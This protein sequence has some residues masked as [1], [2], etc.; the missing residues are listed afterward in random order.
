MIILCSL[1]NNNEMGV[2]GRSDESD[3][4]ARSDFSDFFGQGRVVSGQGSGAMRV[5]SESRSSESWGRVAQPRNWLSEI[6][7]EVSRLR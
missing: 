2:M 5:A 7:T 3:L 6:S 4:S 1:A